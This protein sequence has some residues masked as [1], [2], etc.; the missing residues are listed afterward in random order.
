[1]DNFFVTDWFSGTRLFYIRKVYLKKTIKR[2]NL[3]FTTDNDKTIFTINDLFILYF[4][5]YLFI[6][7]LFF[8]ENFPY[9]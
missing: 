7:V 2:I 8:D 3:R 9:F 1:M 6:C 5:I 4:F